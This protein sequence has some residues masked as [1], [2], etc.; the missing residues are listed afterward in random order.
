MA[1]RPRK[2][3]FLPC[4]CLALML[5]DA[6]Q[7]LAHGMAHYA[8][9]PIS[10]P[11]G[12]V[13]VAAGSAA[14]FIL[15]NTLLLALLWK[16]GWPHAAARAALATGVFGVTF[17]LFGHLVSNSNTAPPPGL[18]WAYPVQWGLGH[19]PHARAIFARWNAFGLLFLASALLLLV[20]ELRRR[21]VLRCALVLAANAAVYALCIVPF[22]A[23]GAITH[24]WPGGYVYDR[25][26]D[27]L[28][29]L[30]GAMLEWSR[31]H[32]GRLPSAETMESLFSELEPYLAYPEN[33]QARPIYFC[34]VGSAFD[35]TP[36]PYIWNSAL[37]RITLR[38]LAQLDRPQPV[39]RCPYA[40]EHHRYLRPSVLYTKDLVEAAKTRDG[41]ALHTRDVLTKSMSFEELGAFSKSGGTEY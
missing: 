8:S 12:F 29:K 39:I 11:Q 33:S 1:R 18:G 15:L 10:P 5:C 34:P 16:V 38:E 31:E 24:G 4:L 13:W 21:H 37:A 14:L 2:V 9:T 3:A 25:C 20:V 22:L 36:R 17:F 27:Q 26:E 6:R 40:G 19:V 30:G 23:S 35:R 32:E 41:P 7:A 28:C